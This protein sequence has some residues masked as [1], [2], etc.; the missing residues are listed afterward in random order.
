MQVSNSTGRNTDYRVGV[1]GGGGSN[2]SFAATSGSP[3]T[4]LLDGLLA[5]GDTELCANSGSWPCTVEFIIDGTLVA[6]QSFSED[7]G[8]VAL[9]ESNGQF[10]IEITPS[11]P[12]YGP[13]ATT[14]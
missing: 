5:P 14:A 6:S 10:S 1:S 3:S 13:A 8:Q 2:F 7:P 11:A 12:D 4:S 9:V